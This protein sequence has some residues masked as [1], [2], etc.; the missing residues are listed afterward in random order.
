M[1]DYRTDGV[2]VLYGGPADGTEVPIELDADS[3]QPTIRHRTLIWAQPVP[4]ARPGTSPLGPRPDISYNVVV[5]LATNVAY[6]DGQGRFRY[7]THG[8]KL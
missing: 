2:A 6:L 3:G 4:L 5:D 1:S 8:T 7:V